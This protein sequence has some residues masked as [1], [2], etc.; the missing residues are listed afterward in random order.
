MNIL[1]PTFAEGMR[2]RGWQVAGDPRNQSIPNEVASRYPW[3]PE[4]VCRI[5]REF[6][7]VVSPD[8]KTWFVTA[9]EIRGESGSAFAWNEW[10]AQSLA[11]AEGDEEWSR[12]ILAF[13]DRHFPILL[14]VADHYAYL[15]VRKDGIAIVGGDEPEFEETVDVAESFEELLTMFVHGDPS[16]ER[17]M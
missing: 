8:E 6:S 13:W 4:Q 1:L 12:V 16:L 11:V 7:A 14:T 5:L 17:W 2:K 10:E 3:L 9:T 15:A